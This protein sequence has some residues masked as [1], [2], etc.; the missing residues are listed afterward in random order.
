MLVSEALKMQDVKIRTVKISGRENAEQQ[1]DGHERKMQDWKMTDSV[2][3][4]ND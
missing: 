3:N 2:H 1:N 4:A